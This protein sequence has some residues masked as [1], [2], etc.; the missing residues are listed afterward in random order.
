MVHAS[1]SAQWCPHQGWVARLVSACLTGFSARTVSLVHRFQVQPALVLEGEV[2]QNSLLHC[3]IRP[4]TIL[5][6]P[7]DGRSLLC[8]QQCVHLPN[9]C[10][11]VSGSV[12]RQRPAS[13]LH[14]KILELIRLA[15]PLKLYFP[16]HTQPHSPS[17]SFTHNHP[18]TVQ[19]SHPP[20]PLCPP[21]QPTRLT[22][23]TPPTTPLRQA[24]QARNTLPLPPRGPSENPQEHLRHPRPASPDGYVAFI[25]C[26]CR[27][28]SLS[29][30]A[31]KDGPALCPA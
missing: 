21:T 15:T 7:R 22:A 3:R 6:Q 16:A 31:A 25:S 18:V 17:V 24:L 2:S 14:S 29:P 11:H 19:V 26:R 13:K 28:H 10:Q 12:P 1:V 20:Q 5:H 4:G 8:Q 27:V 9:A 30:E 23:A